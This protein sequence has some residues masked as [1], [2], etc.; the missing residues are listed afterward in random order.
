MN[1]FQK[2]LYFRVTPIA[3]YEKTNMIN[4]TIKIV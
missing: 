3:I 2:Q 1:L 4:A